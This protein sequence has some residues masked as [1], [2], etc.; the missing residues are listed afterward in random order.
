MNAP[1][2][3]TSLI[4]S[5]CNVENET[6]KILL[7][8]YLLLDFGFFPVACVNSTLDNTIPIPT[9]FTLLFTFSV[10]RKSPPSRLQL[11]V[12]ADFFYDIITLP[13]S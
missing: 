9:C 13:T 12:H 11:D 1:G 10:S 8:V 4:A 5:D 2:C 3:H 7:F 6:F